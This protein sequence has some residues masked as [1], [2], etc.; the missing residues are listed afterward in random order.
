MTTTQIKTRLQWVELRGEDFWALNNNDEW[1]GY[2]IARLSPYFGN[3]NQPVCFHIRYSPH[4]KDLDDTPTLEG[5][6]ALVE[7]YYRGIIALG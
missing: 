2:T 5:A 4:N 1:T 6:K 3:P 7:S